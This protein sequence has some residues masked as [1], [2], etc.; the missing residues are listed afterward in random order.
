MT[1][2]TILRARK[3]ITMNAY[4]PEA[5]HVAIRDGRVLGVG[6]AEDLSGWGS[7]T[8]DDRFAE[9]I[10]MPGFVEGHCHAKEGG[11]WDYPFVGYLDRRDP[12][13]GL[14]EGADSMAKVVDRLSSIER[15]MP[16]GKTL[17]AWGFDPIYFDG[18]RMSLADIDS[19]SKTREI[20]ILHSNGHVINVNSAVLEK[21][22]ISRETNVDGVVKDARGNPTGELAEQAAK[23]MAYRV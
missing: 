4:R 12:D 20:V 21:A 17:F 19:V 14:W 7:A 3:I 6:T 8:N 10:L 16:E 1:A 18:A 15:D 9:H 11:M 22:G 2:T 13:G 5:T 23:Y